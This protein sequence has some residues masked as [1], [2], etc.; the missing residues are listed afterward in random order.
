M[1]GAGAVDKM[2]SLFPSTQHKAPS[3]QGANG[4]AQAKGKEQGKFQEVRMQLHGISPLP[5][6]RGMKRPLQLGHVEYLKYPGQDPR[7]SSGPCVFSP[8]P[9][10][11]EFRKLSLMCVGSN[12]KGPAHLHPRLEYGRA[13]ARD[14]SHHSF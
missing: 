12:S 2:R 8:A 1:A 7:D 10:A 9:P 4:V 13:C 11:W 6:P 3:Q 14:E 5:A